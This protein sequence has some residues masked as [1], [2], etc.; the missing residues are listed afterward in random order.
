MI[1]VKAHFDGKV[2]V[3]DEPV[4]LPKG[5]AVVIHIEL[6][7]AKRKKKLS[8]LDWIVANR[9]KDDNLPTDLSYNLDHYLYGTPKQKPP[10]KKRRQR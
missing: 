8:A 6:K 3:P 4:N 10:R 2:I 9:I 7:P 5:Q 1:A